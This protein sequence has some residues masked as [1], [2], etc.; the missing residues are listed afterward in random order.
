MLEQIGR[1]LR[2]LIRRGTVTGAVLNPVRVLIQASLRAGEAKQSVELF[3]PY[4]RSSFPDAGDVLVL[5]VGAAPDHLVALGADNPALRIPDLQQTEFGDRDLRGQQIAFRLGWLEITTP[6][7]AKFTSGAAPGANPP[8][9]SY[10]LYIDP[11]DG[12]MKLLGSAGTVS[13]LAMP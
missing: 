13:I 3:Q 10:Y 8:A 5:E 11:A 7:F 1:A 2:L 4:G 9:G 12:K 6:K